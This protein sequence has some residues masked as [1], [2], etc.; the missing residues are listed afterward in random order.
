MILT[1]VPVMT[2]FFSCG[3]NNQVE[4]SFTE[5]RLPLTIDYSKPID[6][7]VD[8][9]LYDNATH[10]G[11][12]DSAVFVKGANDQCDTIMDREAILIKLNRRMSSEDIVA[13]MSVQGLRPG[14]ARE[15]LTLGHTYP[16]L[17]LIN[18]ISALGSST[19]ESRIL[20]LW[21]N[22]FDKRY[23][24]FWYCDGDNLSGSLFLAFRD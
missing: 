23:V 8:A 13:Q 1:F 3:E 6:E 21:E 17:Q 18:F 2:L 19:S 12:I 9:G 5:L 14:T 24:S 10:V 16:R 7:L 11:I 20:V 15:L 22:G 4:P